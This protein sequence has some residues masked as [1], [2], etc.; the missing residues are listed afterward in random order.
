M[1]IIKGFIIGIGKIIP[2]ISGSVLAISMGIYDRIIKSFSEFFKDVKNNFKF[3]FQILL[4]IILAI[5][6][7]SKAIYYLINNFY[8]FTLFVISGFILGTLPSLIRKTEYNKKNII[9]TIISFSFVFFLN[10]FLKFSLKTNFIMII[11]LGFIESFSSIV[12]GISGTAILINL[13][14][15][16]FVLENISNLNINFLVFYTIGILI[17]L[18][19]FSKLINYLI[20]KHNQK[21]SSIIN[22]LII[23]SLILILKNCFNTSLNEIIMGIILFIL[24]SFVSYLYN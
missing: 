10:Y 19:I 1:L 4:G 24:S 14:A 3:L 7:G 23:A 20:R 8:T 16:N 22:G 21:F 11:L 2:G 6:F 12:P 9:I 5:L 13:G 17:G 15:Y 18:I